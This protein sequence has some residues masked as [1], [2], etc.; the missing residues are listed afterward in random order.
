MSGVTQ[1]DTKF[2]EV[3]MQ[4]SN[5]SCRACHNFV[6]VRH[7]VRSA[8]HMRGFCKIGGGERE[9]TTHDTI[10][11]ISS[12]TLE[13]LGN[14]AFCSIKDKL[15]EKGYLFVGGVSGGK[16]YLMD[17]KRDSMDI[18]GCENPVRLRITLPYSPEEPKHHPEHNLKYSTI[19]E[20]ENNTAIEEY[21]VIG[22][23]Q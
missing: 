11:P 15:K 12:D 1:I 20:R 2:H 4:P 22:D 5:V 8:H 19:P 6:R 7:N 10:E 23:A 9:M 16:E 18:F 3:I 21:L 13:E 14:A 17:F